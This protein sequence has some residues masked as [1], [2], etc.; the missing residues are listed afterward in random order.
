[1]K[2]IRHISN[3]LLRIV[4]FH[5]STYLSKDGVSRR[6]RTVEPIQKGVVV[7]VDEEL[8]ASRFGTSSV[9]H[10]QSTRSVGDTLVILSNFIGDSTF[11]VALVGISV[12]TLKGRVWR[13]STG[14]GTRAVGVCKDT[15]NV[16]NILRKT[17]DTTKKVVDQHQHRHSY[18]NRLPLA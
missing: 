13:W 1:M 7:D 18:H 3:I 5:S 9:G 6:G 10:T 17:S 16:V 15:R 8:G 2:H 11:G 4:V 14:T 12:G